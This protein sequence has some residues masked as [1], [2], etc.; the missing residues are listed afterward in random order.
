MD[1]GSSA[2]VMARTSSNVSKGALCLPSL[3]KTS[4]VDWT[5]ASGRGVLRG[6]PTS[7]DGLSEFAGRVLGGHHLQRVRL[8][9]RA[10][11]FAAELHVA[12]AADLLGGLARRLQV[13]A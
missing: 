13:V 11:S 9:L 2:A 8:D 4:S 10:L 3:T 7:V 12:L 6:T 1:V 5:R